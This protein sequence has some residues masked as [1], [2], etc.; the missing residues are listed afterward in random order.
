MVSI[1]KKIYRLACQFQRIT[2]TLCEA[3]TQI[4]A[5][6]IILNNLPLLN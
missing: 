2:I 6:K 3:L 4:I 5:S 1:I